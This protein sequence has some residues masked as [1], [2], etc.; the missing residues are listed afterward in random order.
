[1][2]S[3]K[4]AIMSFTYFHKHISEAEGHALHS[5]RHETIVIKL[6]RKIR[7]MHCPAIIVAVIII[8]ILHKLSQVS[9]EHLVETRYHVL[10]RLRGQFA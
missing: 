10:I 8:Q 2:H 3:Q 5:G 7:Q 4:T 6:H 1:M 9:G